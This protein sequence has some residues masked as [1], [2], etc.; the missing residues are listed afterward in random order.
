[1]KI[2]REQTL[3]IEEFGNYVYIN[4]PD[5]SFILHK[6]DMPKD[7]NTLWSYK[8]WDKIFR[9]WTDKYLKN[10]KEGDWGEWDDSN[11]DELQWLK[12]NKI[13]NLYR[14]SPGT[15]S[16]LWHANNTPLLRKIQCE[17]WQSYYPKLT[18]LE[19]VLKAHK[20]WSNLELINTPYYNTEICG[21]NTLH[22][23]YLPTQ[24]ELN[25]W[26]TRN[27]QYPTTGFGHSYGLIHDFPYI[28]KYY[29]DA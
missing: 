11:I 17:F 13:E 7:L 8:N 12:N 24:K 15:D 1:M 21:S 26:V 5:S 14:G 20:K 4:R 19:D 2:S 16:F 3:G 28:K 27:V 6:R 23:C 25:K 18:A 10:Y 29:V 9:F 22:A